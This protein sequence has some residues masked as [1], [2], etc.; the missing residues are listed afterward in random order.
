MWIIYLNCKT[1]M[2]NIAKG[3][4]LIDQSVIKIFIKIF[5]ISFIFFFYYIYFSAS[6]KYQNYFKWTVQ[7]NIFIIVKSGTLVQKRKPFVNSANYGVKVLYVL[8]TGFWLTNFRPVF[9]W[10][11]EVGWFDSLWCQNSETPPEVFCKK[12]CS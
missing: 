2:I 7:W 12:R 11:K 9:S 4:K 1:I 3:R 5:T 6:W 10:H 8:K